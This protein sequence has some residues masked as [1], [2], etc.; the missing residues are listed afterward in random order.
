MISDVCSPH[1]IGA[2]GMV[3]RA[4]NAPRHKPIAEAALNAKQLARL[5]GGIAL[6]CFGSVAS[7]IAR[8]E[9]IILASTTSVEN[10]RW[11]RR[12]AARNHHFRLLS[13]IKWPF[14]R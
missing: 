1:P 13:G 6:L 7:G 12:H 8:A 9:A 3:D 4:S 11:R 2:I 5:W 10:R 14:G